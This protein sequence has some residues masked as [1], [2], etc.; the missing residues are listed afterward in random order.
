MSLQALLSDFARLC[1]LEA[2]TVHPPPKE[3]YPDH[4]QRWSKND[5]RHLQSTAIN[6]KTRLLMAQITG[7]V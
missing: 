5:R 1:E 7:Q 6:V 2:A 3:G 4:K